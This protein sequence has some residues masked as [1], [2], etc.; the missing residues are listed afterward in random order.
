MRSI[1]RPVGRIVVMLATFVGG[2][3]AAASAIHVFQFQP[4]QGMSPPAATYSSAELSPVIIYTSLPPHFLRKPDGIEEPLPDPPTTIEPPPEALTALAAP[5]LDS[6]EILE[7][8][9]RLLELAFDP[10]P[11][12]GVAGPRTQ[13]AIRRYEGARGEVGEGRVTRV[14]LDRLRRDTGSVDTAVSP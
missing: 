8:Q 4:T 3:A 6:F 7:I 13:A 5:E 9:V 11:L 1:R 12:D 14:L 10:G 2:A